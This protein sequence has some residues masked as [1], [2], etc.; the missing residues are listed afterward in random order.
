LSQQSS[1]RDFPTYRGG[2]R[3]ANPNKREGEEPSPQAAWRL[4]SFFEYPANVRTALVAGTRK[5]H[6]YRNFDDVY[7]T[8]NRLIGHYVNG[9]APTALDT[10]YPAQL[11]AAVEVVSTAVRQARSF[12]EAS[13]AT[14]NSVRPV[15]LFYGCLNLTKA[16]VASTFASHPAIPGPHGLSFDTDLQRISTHAHGEFPAFHD[17]VSSG[18][19]IYVPGRT[20]DL[21]VLFAADPE[22]FEALS[23]VRGKPP[24][25]MTPKLTD[26]V[27]VRITDVQGEDVSTHVMAVEFMAI[28]ALSCWSRY[29]PVEWDRKLRGESTGDAYIYVALMDYVGHDFP[30]RTFSL[31]T[32]RHHFFGPAKMSESDFRKRFA[33]EMARVM[34]P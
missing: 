30:I 18:R 4:L 14:P 22:L 19:D 28:F 6:Q 34:G 26:D 23:R 12:F 29:K 7:Y 31:L 13:L 11:E 17:S 25:G 5:D 24:G 33:E 1:R 21:D 27:Q 16:L 32:G 3:P 2:Y 20:F 8:A 10:T 9:P 15:L